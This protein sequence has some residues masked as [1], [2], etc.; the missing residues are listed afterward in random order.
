MIMYIENSTKKL[1]DLVNEF[2]KV[3]RYKII[4]NM[5]HFYILMNYK[6]EKSGNSPILQLPQKEKI[7]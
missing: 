6:K 5:L 2:S 4:K 1:L 3:W 7:T